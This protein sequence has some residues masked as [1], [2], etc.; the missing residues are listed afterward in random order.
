VIGGGYRSHEAGA[1]GLRSVCATELL[2]RFTAPEDFRCRQN[3][4]AG[5]NHLGA[6][7]EQTT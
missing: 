4:R 6:G 3:V 1:I 2:G 7:M 5:V